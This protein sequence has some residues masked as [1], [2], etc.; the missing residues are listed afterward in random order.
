MLCKREEEEVG[1]DVKFDEGDYA[2]GM[3]CAEKAERSVKW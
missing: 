1:G 2:C 3:E